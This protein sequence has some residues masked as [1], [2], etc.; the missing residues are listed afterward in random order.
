MESLISSG[1]IVDIACAVM[2]AEALLLFV[3]ARRQVIHLDRPIG[4]LANLV[5][6]AALM[7]ALRVGLTASAWSWIAAFLAISLLAHLVDLASR[8]ATSAR[9]P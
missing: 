1:R 5:S 7:L 8:F 4:L 6:G 2:V 3:L 9:Q